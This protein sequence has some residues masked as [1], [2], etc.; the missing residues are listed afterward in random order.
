MAEPQKRLFLLDGM[1]LIYRAHFA[2]I[3]NPQFT[4]GGLCTS[5]VMGMANTLLDLINKHNPTHMVCVFDTPEATQRHEEYPEYKAQ[6]ESLPEDIGD[7]LPYV[8]EL[9]GGF[10]IPV[11]RIPGYEADDIIGTLAT[12]AEAKGFQ[13]WMVTPDKDYDQLVTD[14]IFVLKPGRKGG[15]QEI[16]GVQE[17]LHKWEIERINQVIDILGLM[18]DSSDNIPGVPGIGPKTAQKLIAAYGSIE[19]L[20][21]N[22]DKLKG[23]QKERVEENREMALLSKK[24]VTI[25]LDVPHEESHEKFQC[26][27]FD[28]ERLKKLFMEMEFET[29]G[30]RVFGNSYTAAP[31]RQARIREEREKEIQ[32]ELF[33]EE[34][35]VEEKSVQN[36]QHDYQTIDTQAQRDDLLKTLLK[37][38]SIC[39]DAET[40]GLDPREACPL[41]L[42]FS[43]EPHRAFYVVI[44]EDAEKASQVLEQFRTVFENES[45]E[46]VGHN[47]KYDITLLKWHGISVQGRLF[48]TMLAHSMKEPEM[49]HGLD[50]LS[51]LYLGYTPIPIS[52]LIGEKGEEQLNLREVPIE[53]VAEYAC[54][55]ADVTLQI[56]NVLRPEIESGGFADVCCSVEC[57]LVAVL[58]DMEHEGI[59][60]DV[61]ALK[62]YSVQLEQEIEVLRKSIFDS[63]GHEFNIESPKQL[64]IV[65]YEELVL[66][67]NPKKTATGQYS[68]RESELQKLAGKHQVVRDVLD[69]RNAVKLK[70]VYVDQLPDHVNPQTGRVH[71]HYLQAWTAT[72]RMQ[73]NEPNLQT[74]PIRKQRGKE[75][76]A[77]FVS[78]DEDHLLL[79]ADY[80]QIE[81][82]VM[83]ELSQ[84]EGLL[85]AFRAGTDIHQV[86]ASKVYK[87]PLEEVTREM[88]DKAKT[89]NFGILYGISA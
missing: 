30:K 26:Q 50:Y 36:V 77:A 21:A 43:F 75:I 58:V 37:Q 81:L 5:A 25:Q 45:I 47:L 24:L 49:R 6:R 15:E 7:Q 86:T 33:G 44:P 52:E 8:D 38:K 80:S 27:P 18:G 73:S 10:K 83:A 4:T 42:S 74:I 16:F 68:T 51:K 19:N 48:D 70:S 29:L 65:L 85:E 89:V 12:Q 79:A 13:S 31:T 1:A 53:K 66:E 56:A 17:V 46:K 41:G 34:E 60:L 69:F 55:D 63:V 64:G 11:I 88:R 40:T 9:L 20:L 32:G 62:K 87:V 39:F 76:R 82:R 84:D 59:R 61:S 54:E 14:N 35:V 67:K 22:T 3:R 23:K 71:T 78:R 2:L 28:K 72:G 57:P